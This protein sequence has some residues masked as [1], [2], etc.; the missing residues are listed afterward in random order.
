[1]ITEDVIKDIYRNYSKPVKNRDDLRLDYFLDLLKPIH[2]LHQENDEII[3]G[4]LEEFSPFRRFLI[5][6]LHAILESAITFCFS[7]KRTSNSPSISNRRRKNHSSEGYSHTT[8]DF[9]TTNVI[10]THQAAPVLRQEPPDA[11]ERNK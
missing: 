9:A 5:R 2:K 8:I 6:S 7:V 3:V 1:M 10:P 4:N 11:S